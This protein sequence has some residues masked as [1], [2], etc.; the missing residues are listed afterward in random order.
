MKKAL[1]QNG[2]G[3]EADKIYVPTAEEMRQMLEDNFVDVI[4]LF[5]NI[6][7]I[8]SEIM[9]IKTYDETMWQVVTVSFGTKAVWEYILKIYPRYVN[10]IYNYLT[11]K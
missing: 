7:K 5:F 2:L 6:G 10:M 9:D 11:K 1:R 4:R 3:Q 8:V